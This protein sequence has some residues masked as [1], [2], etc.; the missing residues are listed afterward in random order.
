MCNTANLC[1]FSLTAFLVA[2]QFA[3]AQQS[4][5][6]VYKHIDSQGRV[7]YANSP[8]KGGVIVELQPLTII[9]STP[10]GSL[11][12]AAKAAAIAATAKQVVELPER[13]EVPVVSETPTAR[14][15]STSSTQQAAQA[16]QQRREDV[17]RRILDGEIETEQQLV[18]E[19]KTLLDVEQKR[20]NALRTMRASRPADRAPALRA[21]TAPAAAG[22]P[23]LEQPV[24][25][26]RAPAIA[27]R[28]RLPEP[29]IVRRRT[30]AL[31]ASA[32]GTCRRAQAQ[33]ATPWAAEIGVPIA[34]QQPDPAAAAAHPAWA[35]EAA[36]AGEG[37]RS[38]PR[39]K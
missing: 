16:A 7:T 5:V 38:C 3:W 29:A 28:P 24:A 11:G 4:T 9:P 30:V 10:G 18:D 32:T 34:V 37:D 19:V 8:I 2:G 31:T 21:V 22:H 1:R 17:R 35:R 25:A 13:V 39:T 20:S 6:V 23:R 36:A 14:P 12:D 26:R 33:A 15:T 27:R